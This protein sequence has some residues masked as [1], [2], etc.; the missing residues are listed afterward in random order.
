[1]YHQS[2]N[3]GSKKEQKQLQSWFSTK[4]QKKFRD[5]KISEVK[6]IFEITGAKISSLNLVEKYTK[7][8]FKKLN[9]I[10]LP[11]E[12]KEMFETFGLQLMGRKF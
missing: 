4:T 3:K 10:K 7:E 12:S 11:V 2:I 6:K 9:D 5:K 1:M 8:A